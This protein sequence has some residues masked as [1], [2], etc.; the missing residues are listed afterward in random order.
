MEWASF[1]TC[2]PQILRSSYTYGVIICEVIHL[3][4]VL[5]NRATD[6]CRLLVR[7]L[8][9]DLLQF[10]WIRIMLFKTVSFSSNV[11]NFMPRTA[12]FQAFK[13]LNL[14][15]PAHCCMAVCKVGNLDSHH[16]TERQRFSMPKIS[17]NILFILLRSFRQFYPRP[18]WPW[19]MRSHKNNFKTE[20]TL[21]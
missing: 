3:T 12:V 1:S 17:H 14:L 9:T 2:G 8:L 10:Q 4:W 15:K 20:D 7:N 18:C 19:I 13:L 16:Q 5:A 6:D 11:V 21:T